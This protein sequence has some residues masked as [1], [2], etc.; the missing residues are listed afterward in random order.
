M[1]DE[2]FSR[3][4]IERF[5]RSELSRD[6]NRELVRHLLRQCPRCTQILKEV[7]QRQ[8]FRF[9]IHAFEDTALRF[10]PERRTKSLRRRPSLAAREAARAGPWRARGRD[11][12]RR[13]GLR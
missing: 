2:H 3:E 11:A 13:G 12:I 1:A 8:D 9:L 5:F 10:D 6:E 7:A 4:T